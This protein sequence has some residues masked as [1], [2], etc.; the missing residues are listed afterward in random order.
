MVLS[1]FLMKFTLRGCKLHQPNK[2]KRQKKNKAKKSNFL[3]CKKGKETLTPFYFLK[4]FINDV[5]HIPAYKW[6]ERFGNFEIRR[7]WNP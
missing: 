6:I 3:V 7:Y 4:G 5:Y 1:R 2:I